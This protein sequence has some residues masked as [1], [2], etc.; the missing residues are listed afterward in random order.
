MNLCGDL[1]TG[2]KHSFILDTDTRESALQRLYPFVMARNV[3]AFHMVGMIEAYCFDNVTAGLLFLSESA[4]CGYNPSRYVLGIMLRESNKTESYRWLQDAANDGYIP[5]LQ[6]ILPANEMKDR[7]GDLSADELKKYFL[8][9]YGVMK[10]MRRNY[11]HPHS[12]SH[13][14][15]YCSS[16]QYGL[17]SSHCWNPLCGK[18]AY[19]GV[20]V[21]G[22]NVFNNEQERNF[23]TMYSDLVLRTQA[24][25]AAAGETNNTVVRFSSGGSMGITTAAPVFLGHANTTTQ[26]APSC[27]FISSNNHNNNN[28]NVV[29]VG[30]TE[31]H[32]TTNDDDATTASS[33]TIPTSNTSTST[34]SFISPTNTNTNNTNSSLFSLQQELN[35]FMRNQPPPMRVARMKM[36]SV[37]RRAKYCSKLCQVY[38]WRSGRHKQE[39]RLL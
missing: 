1:N 4:R 14:Q 31:N 12:H 24:A 13:S 27:T 34:T 11:C 2:G 38:D 39:C 8:D 6:E 19:K 26:A 29:I 25:A 9:H 5:A 36:C 18:W 30:P 33:C 21:N 20:G 16:R 37:C 35:L 15:H 22:V 23:L 28:N 3:H 32:S 7:F 17:A 10:L